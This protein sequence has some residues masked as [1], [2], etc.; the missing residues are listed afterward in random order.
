MFGYCVLC[1]ETG[2]S[3]VPSEQRDPTVFVK[4][5]RLLLLDN[6]VDVYGI[7]SGQQKDSERLVSAHRA[8]RRRPPIIIRALA[9]PG[10]S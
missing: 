3:C 9:V 10:E 1:L 5:F 6:T 7:N 4:Y 8:S 2:V